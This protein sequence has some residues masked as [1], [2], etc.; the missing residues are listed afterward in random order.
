MTSKME[1][2]NCKIKKIK[3]YNIIPRAIIQ[4]LT[5]KVSIQFVV[6]WQSL[7]LVEHT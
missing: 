1:G 7:A 3:I 6:G 5:Y 2:E 4:C